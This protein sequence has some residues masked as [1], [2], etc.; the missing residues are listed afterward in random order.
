VYKRLGQIGEENKKSEEKQPDQTNTQQNNPNIQ[1]SDDGT[2]TSTL[3]GKV[4]AD[5]VTPVN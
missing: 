4:T 3:Y 2:K 1:L 5:T